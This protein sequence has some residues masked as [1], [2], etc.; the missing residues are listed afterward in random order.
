MEINLKNYSSPG[1]LRNFVKW[2]RYRGFAV[3]QYRLERQQLVPSLSP[4]TLIAT[5]PGTDSAFTDTA[6]MACNKSFNYRVF[7][8]KVGGGITVKSAEV[9][10]SPF[11][12]VRP[13]PPVVYYARL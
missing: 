7:A 6:N 2:S 4:W 1:Q 5:L 12:S 8:D 9:P 11:D 3:Q 13:T 10:L